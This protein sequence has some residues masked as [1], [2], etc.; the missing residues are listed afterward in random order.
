LKVGEI[1]VN[2][3][4]PADVNVGGVQMWSMFVRLLEVIDAGSEVAEE[5]E[6]PE[7]RGVAFAVNV[8][9]RNTESRKRSKVGRS[10]E[11]DKGR[12]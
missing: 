12:R 4:P 1:V 11:Q 2:F 10:T 9:S 8:S 6:G 7:A 3:V 5:G